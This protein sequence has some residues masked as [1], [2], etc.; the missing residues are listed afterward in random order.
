MN[1]VFAIILLGHGLF[2]IIGFMKAFQLAEINNFTQSISKPIGLLWLLVYIL[3]MTTLVLFLIHESWWFVIAFIAVIFSQVLIFMFWNTAKFGSLV[4]LII[5]LISCSAL[6]NYN[7]NRMVKMETKALLE[8]AIITGKG[9]VTEKESN[10]LPVCVK[11]W[12]YNSGVTG[13]E[14]ITTVYLKQKGGMKTKPN[15]NGMPFTAEQYF[16]VKDAGF[17]WTTEVKM[18][19]LL[20][21]IGRDKLNHGEGAMLIKLLGLIPV[22][23]QSKNEKINS[24]AQLRF[25]AEICWFPSAALNDYLIWEG[26]NDTSAKATLTVNGRSVSGIFSFTAQ[27]DFK[28]FEANRYYGGAIDSTLEKWR[29]EA[30]EYKSFDGIRIPSQCKVIWKLDGSDFEWLKLEIIEWYYNI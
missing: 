11:K 2:H 5:L 18:N 7:F 30:I 21:L 3:F 14:E 28:S 13:R 20:S 19:P 24:G 23:N 15:S 10:H 1:P 27:G 26:V 17:I 8:N 9:V 12:L 29:I 22:V 25:L 6:G 4:N 16:N